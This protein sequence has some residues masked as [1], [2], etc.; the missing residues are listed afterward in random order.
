[1]GA[2]HLTHTSFES[3]TTEKGGTAAFSQIT[4]DNLIYFGWD[5]DDK[6]HQLNGYFSNKAGLVGSFFT[7]YNCLWLYGFCL[8]QP[9]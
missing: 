7:K 4:L 2:A 1:V 6:T 3:F 5:N 9:G 8:G